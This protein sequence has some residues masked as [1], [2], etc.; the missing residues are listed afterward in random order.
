MLSAQDSSQR[1]ADDFAWLP[2]GERSFEWAIADEGTDGKAHFVTTIDVTAPTPADLPEVAV[3]RLVCCY[4]I[5][6]LSD[7][8][9]ADACEKLTDIYSWQIAQENA[10]RQV[11]HI[12]RTPGPKVRR[13]E[14]SPFTFDEG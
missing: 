14:R 2:L 13:V 12:R 7:K 4:V 8:A 5:M 9:L 6:R 1:P 3:H 10:P 11:S